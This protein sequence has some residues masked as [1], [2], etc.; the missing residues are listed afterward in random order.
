MGRTTESKGFRF[1]A[2][3][4]GTMFRRIGWPLA[5]APSNS[6]IACRAE[7]SVRYVTYAV[8][9]ERPARSYESFSSV[10]GAMRV[11]RSCQE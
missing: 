9:R 3:P 2:G 1:A 4:E 7:R 6:A 10:I 11:K 5:F 8:P